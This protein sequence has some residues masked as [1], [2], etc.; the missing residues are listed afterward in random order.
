MTE[1]EAREVLAILLPLLRDFLA[2]APA[3]VAARV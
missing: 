3:A 1:K 2:Q